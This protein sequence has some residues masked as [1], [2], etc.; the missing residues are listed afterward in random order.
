MQT[1]NKLIRNLTIGTIAGGLIGGGASTFVLNNKKPFIRD[2]VPSYQVNTDTTIKTTDGIIKLKPPYDFLTE[3]QIEN[4]NELEVK[5]YIPSKDNYDVEVYGF[6]NGSLTSD[7]K[8]KK[9]EQFENGN[10]LSTITNF[11][12]HDEYQVE[13]KELP[14]SYKN[15][16]EEINI[17][18]IDYDSVIKVRESR[19]DNLKDTTF[20]LLMTA[21]G[22]V[23]GFIGS[24]VV[25]EL[26]YKVKKKLK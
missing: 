14:T 20:W 24:N 5:S 11:D 25:N 17:K 21:V 9:Q 22:S 6:K 2:L 13:A 23:I 16:L 4:M 15:I 8:I 12:N 18:T 19:K 7:E 10:T 26:S 3:E 1:I